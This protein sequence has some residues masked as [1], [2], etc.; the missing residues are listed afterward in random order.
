MG[1][2]AIGSGYMSAVRLGV[3]GVVVPFEL[4]L[5]LVTLVL[6]EAQLP[7]D[8]FDGLV[9]PLLHVH[10]RGD[11]HVEAGPAESSRVLALAVEAA[12]LQHTGPLVAG[13]GAGLQQPFLDVVTRGV[14]L[15][16]SLQLGGLCLFG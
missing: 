3:S 4:G 7:L 13:R 8:L 16:E 14:E 10:L 15:E 12:R 9:A 1:L 5:A 6:Q 2:L 11:D